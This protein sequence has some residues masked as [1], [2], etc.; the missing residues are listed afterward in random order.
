MTTWLRVIASR[1]GAVFTR[2]RLDHEFDDELRDHLESLTEEYQAE[3]W[4]L[5][6]GFISSFL[7]MFVFAHSGVWLYLLKV[8]G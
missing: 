3:L 8:V 4:Q 2:Q 6:V 7:D 1:L 5:L